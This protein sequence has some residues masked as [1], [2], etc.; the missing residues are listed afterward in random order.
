MAPTA[1]TD[2]S[3]GPAGDDVLPSGEVRGGERVDGLFD[4]RA[5]EWNFLVIGIAKVSER[6]LVV[7]A[8]IWLESNFAPRTSNRLDQL[9]GRLIVLL[10][11]IIHLEG[12]GTAEKERGR[13]AGVAR[14]SGRI[15]I[16][17]H[18]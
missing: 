9:P 14:T 18:S 6:E 8:L 15:N 12:T 11:S 13:D 4:A 16:T 3:P 7:T 5:V 10:E 1:A 17:L 2:N